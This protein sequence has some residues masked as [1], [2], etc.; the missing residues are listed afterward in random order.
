MTTHHDAQQPRN[1]MSRRTFIAGSTGAAIMALGAKKEPLAWSNWAR[2]VTCNPKYI[3]RPKSEKNVVQLVNK[4]AKEGIRIGMTGS[5]HSFMPVCSTDGTLISLAQMNGVET[6]L[7]RLE[8]RILGGTKIAKMHLPLREGGLAMENI[9]DIDRQAITGAIAT[10]SHGTGHGIRSIPN[11]VIGLRL[12]TASGDV[13]E[14]SETKERDI[15]KA[16][17]VSLGVLG[18]I[19]EVTMKMMPTYRLHEKMWSAPFEEIYEKL[20]DYIADNRHFEFFWMSK[21]DVCFVKTLNI[22]EADPDELPDKKGERI[23]HSDIIFPSIR[24]TRFN[25]IEFSVPEKEGPEDLLEVRELMLKKWPEVTM[26]LEYRTVGADD[27]PLSMMSG[28]DTVTISAHEFANRPFDK[29][30]ADVEAIHRNHGGR[31]HWGKIHTFT[32]EDLAN[33]Y[34]AFGDFNKIRKQL[35]PNGMFLN[36]LFRGIFA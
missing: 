18:V 30:F 27:I 11:Q 29:F 35:D 12:V 3:E 31:P 4:A 22:V 9:S 13:I 14:C 10:G 23:N 20:D 36:D 33:A 1:Q 16:A 28:R 26:P 32:G 6:D 8:A 25:E 24:N 5:G 17:Q 19:T 15:F 7:G 34:P 21:R 2:S